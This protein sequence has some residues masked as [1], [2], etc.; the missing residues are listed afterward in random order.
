MQGHNSVATS[1]SSVVPLFYVVMWVVE[2]HGVE[3]LEMN[4]LFVRLCDMFTFS[5]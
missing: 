5:W 2:V 4:W 3:L 1:H